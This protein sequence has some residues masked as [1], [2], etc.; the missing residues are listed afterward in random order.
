M[1]KLK[2]VTSFILV[3]IM[4]FSSSI[5]LHASSEKGVDL[6][7]ER[8]LKIIED[9]DMEIIEDADNIPENTIIFDTVEEFEEF[10]ENFDKLK[11]EVIVEI[12][13]ND[14]L[15]KVDRQSSDYTLNNVYELTR[16]MICKLPFPYPDLIHQVWFDHYSNGSFYACESYNDGELYLSGFSAVISL[17][18]EASDGYVKNGTLFVNGRGTLNINILVEGILTLKKDPFETHFRIQPNLDITHASFTWL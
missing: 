10:I 2:K 13:D 15:T 12:Q 4:L 18:R 17:S 9:N 5:T 6:N 7:T 11:E 16:K 1:Y 8:I 3:C 14:V